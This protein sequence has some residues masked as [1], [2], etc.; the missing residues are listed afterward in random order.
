MDQRPAA[1]EY[2]RTDFFWYIDVFELRGAERRHE[3][4]ELK[5]RHP[6]ILNV[7]R[8]HSDII[9]AGLGRVNAPR[10]RMAEGQWSRSL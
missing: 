10:R 6:R 8:R 7:Q 2:G 1:I 9:W 3:E 4:H 5:V